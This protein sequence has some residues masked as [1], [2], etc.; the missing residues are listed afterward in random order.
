MSKL[1]ARL[2]RSAKEALAFAEWQNRPGIHFEGPQ[3]L[4]VDRVEVIDLPPAPDGMQWVRT[5]VNGDK[6]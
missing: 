1:G 3:H 2:I 4:I 5:P 6:P